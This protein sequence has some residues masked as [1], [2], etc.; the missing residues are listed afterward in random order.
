M[1]E[2]FKNVWDALIDEPGERESCKIKSELMIAVEQFINEQ[3]ITQQ[4][5]AKLMGVTQPR[6]SNIVNGNIDR[7]TIDMLI[8]MLARIDSKIRLEVY[9]EAE[10][11]AKNTRL[12]F[13]TIIVPSLSNYKRPVADIAETIALRGYGHRRYNQPSID[14]TYAALA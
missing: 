12:E 9:D 5:A 6:I 7:I 1:T 2:A 11:T 4:Q 8:K 14:T 10:E 13:V 3:G